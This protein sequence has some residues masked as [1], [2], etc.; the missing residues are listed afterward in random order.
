MK[1]LAF[2]ASSSKKSIN[3]KLVTY[4]TGLLDNVQT[5]ILDLNDYELPLF[6]EDKEL[7][8]G[9]PQL[10]QDFLSKIANS[11][12]VIISFAEHNGF[13]SAAYKNLFDWCSRINQKVFQG[14][15]MILLATSPGK[16]G[17]SSVLKSAT[18]SMPFFDGNVIGSLSVPSF[19]ENF[20]I[21]TNNI[22]NDNIN[23]DLKNLVQK[24]V[25]N[26][27]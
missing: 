13:Y 26:N 25:N 23:L 5:E 9:K 27:I 10:A 21:K 22:T 3:K 14:K 8:I 20:D 1:I 11:D 6:S 12:A 2:A 19:Y 15:S 24:L 16:G 4:A 7:E 17:A 18:S